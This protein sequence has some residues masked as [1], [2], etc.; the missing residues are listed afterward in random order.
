MGEKML[1][2]EIREITD[3][4]KTARDWRLA[5]LRIADIAYDKDEDLI[6]MQ[7]VIAQA[8]GEAALDNVLYAMQEL[9]GPTAEQK[10]DKDLRDLHAYGYSK[11]NMLVMTVEQAIERFRHGQAVHILMSDNTEHPAVSE[12]EIMQHSLNDGY[13]GAT[14]DEIKD[15][16]NGM[17]E[18]AGLLDDI[19]DLDKE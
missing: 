7:S 2:D 12:E 4:C 15:M 18:E 17:L 14:E 10:R 9:K 1:Q 3:G 5:A 6:N 8:Y 11:D 19:N 13:L 16:I